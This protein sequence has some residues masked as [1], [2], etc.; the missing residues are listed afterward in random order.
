MKS[1]LQIRPFYPAILWTI[2]IFWAS[3]FFA[4]ENIP[5]TL[6]DIFETDKVGHFGVYA[7]FYFLWMYGLLK[8]GSKLTKID[9]IIVILCCIGYGVL[10]EYI[11]FTFFPGRYFEIA[12]ILANIIGSFLGL[13]F[14]RIWRNKF[15]KGS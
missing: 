14:F 9:F 11:Q 5:E 1:S 2:F 10:M 4:G 6:F 12:D 8:S 3:T 13:I 15:D 7:I